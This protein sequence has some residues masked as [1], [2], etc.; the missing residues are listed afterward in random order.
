MAA[1]ILVAFVA[2]SLALSLLLATVG[3]FFRDTRDILEV[4]LPVLFWATP[5]FYEPSMAPAFLRPALQLNPLSPFIKAMRGALLLAEAPS[6]ADVGLIA[7]WVV[8]TAAI[9]I[10][11]FGRF[12]R[13]FAEEA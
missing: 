8:L 1:V 6:L 5:I 3:V 12:A 10:W 2:F 11:V 13:H 4:G 7:F 9:G